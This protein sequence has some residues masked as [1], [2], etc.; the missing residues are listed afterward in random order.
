MS[1]L[2]M[3]CL[4][5]DDSLLTKVKN[6]NYV[7][8]GL[9]K[10]N[11]STEWLR[12]N[13]KINISE[14]NPFYG[15]H[16][17][18]YW[19]WKN[20]LNN[21]TDGTWIGFCTYRRFWNQKKDKKNNDTFNIFKDSLKEVPSEWKNFDTIL[22]DKIDLT[23]LKWMKVLKYGKLA[24]L[25]NPKAIFKDGRNIRFNF[26]M[27]HGN[28]ILDK[29]I[30]LLNDEDKED[31]RKFVNTNTSINQCNLFICRSKDKIKKYYETIFEWFEKLEQIFGFNLEG[32]SKIRIYGFLSERF[33]P[34]WFMKNSNCIEW[35]ISFKDLNTQSV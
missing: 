4:C 14:K 6:L 26:D 29:A 16:S 34:Y 21:I 30:E 13:T 28:G 33:L 11:F 27:F 23:N 19:L 9:G 15:E 25:R 2:L 3:Y 17:F 24:L 22:A 35:P 1:N 8:V 7:P 32:Y 18:H 10:N 31:F 20:K 5:L 12:D